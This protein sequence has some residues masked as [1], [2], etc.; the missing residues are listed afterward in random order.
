MSTD[1]PDWDPFKDD[2]ADEAQTEA[3]PAEESPAD[4]PA[5]STPSDDP[6]KESGPIMAAE[7]NWVSFTFLGD[8]GYDKLSGTV[9]GDPEFVAKTLNVKDFDGRI[10]TLMKQAV[11]IDTWFKQTA[12]KA[13]PEGDQGK[14]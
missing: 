3:P 4:K 7:D 2:D 12:A 8:S 10:S 13:K 5:G 11:A 9:H 14:G 6:W 1:D